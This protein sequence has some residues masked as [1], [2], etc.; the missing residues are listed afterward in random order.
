MIDRDPGD[1]ECEKCKSK[2]FNTLGILNCH[3]I[4]DITSYLGCLTKETIQ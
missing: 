3:I 2:R 4:T 1:F